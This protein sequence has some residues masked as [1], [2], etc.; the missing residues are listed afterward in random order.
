VPLAASLPKAIAYGVLAALSLSVG[1]GLQ[2]YGLAFVTQPRQTLRER[3]HREVAAWCTGT[4]G[5][6]GSAFFVFAACAYG[7]VSLVAALSGTG[8]VGL[9][10]FSAWALRERVG[11]T[12][13]AGI[14][15]VV[16]GTLLVGCFDAWPRLPGY[17]LARRGTGGLH[18]GNLIVYA[19]GIVAVSLAAAFASVRSGYRAFGLVFG[20]IA[21]LCGG[22]SVFFQKAAMIQCA[23]S[24]IFADIPS[25]VRMP[26]FYLFA[27]T[28]LGDFAVTQY[29]LTRA[30]A[31]TVVPS[32]QVFN[33]LV[34]VVGGVVA[35]YE[36]L[37]ALQIVGVATLAAG[38]GLLSV[39]VGQ[40]ER[41]R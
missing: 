39:F 40:G 25:T 9:V 36:R 37:N 41:E 15:L 22:L 19:S 2:K 24:D 11:K 26:Y 4:A 34:P 14:A 33:M 29:A 30:K 35:Y 32:Y 13:L 28:G 12:E 31:V 17:G 10:A 23:C 27:L 8:L 16:T 21:G 7:P 38:T 5:V 20:S 18:A 6:V 1:K 3:K